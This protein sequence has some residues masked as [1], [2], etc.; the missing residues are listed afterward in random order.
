M[1]TE[2]TRY[3]PFREVVDRLFHR[4]D[5]PALP[6]DGTD[7]GAL[8]VDISET[9]DELIVRASLP[10]FKKD[11]VDVQLHQ[12][13][14]AIKAEHGGEREGH[15]NERYH[16]RERFWG[17]VSRRI[18]LPGLVHDADVTA[19]MRDGVLALRIPVPASAKPKK[20]LI[21]V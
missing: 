21:E 3:D 8:G 2:L 1:A 19:E 10:G 18:A 13:V 11:E 4:L 6:S 9:P 16:R 15:D 17:S 7:E 12:G 14:L 20:I 5:R